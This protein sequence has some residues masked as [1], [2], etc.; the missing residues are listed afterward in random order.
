M[1]APDSLM[2]DFIRDMP[3]VELHV[4][5]QGAVQPATL[6]KLAKRNGIALPAD[7]AEELRQW[8]SFAG[9]EH[10]IEVYDLICEC[11]RT[12]DDIESATR[13][14]LT[15]QAAQ[16]IIYTELTYTPSRGRMNFS[17]QLDAINR[18][19]AWA[20]ETLGIK[21]N[22]VID[23]PREDVGKEDG[24]LIADWAVSA[25]GKGVVALGLGG[26][27]KGNPPE[28][29]A[30]A[31]GR[32]HAAGLPV[33]PHAGEGAG[34]ESIW[35]AL[36]VAKAA[37][38]GHGVRCLEDPALVNELR[39][40]Q[41]PLEVCPTSNVLLGVFASMDDH[42]LPRLIEEGL[43][44]TIGSDDPAMFGITLTDEY[45]TIAEK[46]GFDTEMIERLV[47]N[48]VQAALLDEDERSQ[49]E[50]EF[51]DRKCRGRGN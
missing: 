18:A 1:I 13:E 11:F 44:V 4:H 43:C 2:R 41:V 7:N 16:K 37:R 17:E 15:G 21:M 33:V 12:P 49:I 8:Y 30:D 9:F 6:L 19:R 45:I 47:L 10:F 32:A 48:G 26:M 31:F 46:F 36:R 14:F 50:R 29:F 39:R 22:T 23:I 24:L 51:G 40:R 20:S 42:P 38:I 27:E 3:K 28:E 25:M 34:P 35:S 5:L